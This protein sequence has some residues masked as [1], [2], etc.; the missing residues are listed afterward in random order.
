MVMNEEFFV[1]SLRKHSQL[2]DLFSLLRDWEG[3]KKDERDRVE[4]DME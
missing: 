1:V 4:F 2:V 3:T